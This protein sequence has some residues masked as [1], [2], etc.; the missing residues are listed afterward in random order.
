M[1]EEGREGGRGGG[2]GRGGVGEWGRGGGGE[3]GRAI[4]C[5]VKNQQS[6]ILLCTTYSNKTQGNHASNDNGVHKTF[7]CVYIY[8]HV[9]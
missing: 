3:G 2:G 9:A 6:P 4:S 8:I 7:T 5:S 1:S